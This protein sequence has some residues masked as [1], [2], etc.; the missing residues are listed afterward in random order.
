VI[1]LLRFAHIATGTVALGSFWIPLVARKGGLV[2]RRAGWVYAGSMWAATFAAWVICVARLSDGDPSNDA[3]AVFLGFVGLLSANGAA[4]GIRVMRRRR[5]SAE[6]ARWIDLG[7][8]ALF[9]AASLALGGWGVSKGAPLP[10]A[11]GVLGLFLSARQLLYWTRGPRTKADWWTAHLGNM[12]GACIGTVT[13]FLVVNVPR[14]GL[15]RY[16]LFFWLGPGVIGGIGIF[17]WTRYYERTLA[18]PT[19]R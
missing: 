17:L 13:A 6:G 15:E 18:V 7:S 2:H 14:F 11:F 9:L 3:A 10:I 4:T 12:I 8:S 5:R 1:D 19:G 16:G